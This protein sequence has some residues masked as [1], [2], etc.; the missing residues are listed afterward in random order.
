MLQFANMCKL[1][2]ARNSTWP[3]AHCEYTISRGAGAHGRMGD[4]ATGRLGGRGRTHTIGV[5]S[6]Q[7]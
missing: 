3:F 6:D 2:K 5:T 4:W 1:W 7:C